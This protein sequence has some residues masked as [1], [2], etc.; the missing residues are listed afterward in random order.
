MISR[1]NL[2]QEF[3]K[4]VMISRESL[5]QEFKKIVSTY[6]PESEKV[7]KF[8]YVKVIDC[9]IE[10]LGRRFYYVGV[11][12]PEALI[13]SIKAQHSA[14]KEISENMGLAGVVCM[15]ANHIIRDPMSKLKQETPHL[16]M[17]LYW[18]AVQSL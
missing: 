14:F 16:W 8:C 15:N 7:L 13:T 2:A 18:I 5:A 1:E 4:I 12:Y 17:E 3:K 10:R 9:Y 11:Y 6:Y